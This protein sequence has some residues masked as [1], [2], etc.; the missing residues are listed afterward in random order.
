MPMPPPNIANKNDFVIPVILF[1]VFWK[2]QVLQSNND[3]IIG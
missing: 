2:L 3:N 1:F